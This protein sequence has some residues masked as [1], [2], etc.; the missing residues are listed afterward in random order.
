MSF[1][2]SSA[3]AAAYGIAVTGT[4]AI[5]SVIYFLVLTET[6]HWPRWKALPLVGL[7]LVF[8]LAFFGANLLKF[9]DGGWFPVGL[10]TVIFLIMTTWKKGRALLARNLADKLLPV[11]IFLEDLRTMNP[12]RVPG[13]AVFMSSNPNGVPVVLLH[14]WKHNQVLHQTV[15]LLSVISETLPEIPSSRRVVAKDL[16]QGF[17]HI[18]AFYGFMET[19]NVPELMQSA[20]DVHKVPYKPG[21][22]SYY[23]GRE[24]LLATK[25]SGM[26]PW[27]KMLFSFISRN[28]RSATQYFGIPP[29]RV[30]ELGMQI[31]L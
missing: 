31:D 23:L 9:P 11:S 20:A 27:R 22:T 17:F 4:M 1:K 28:S 30:V 13:T 7:F 18:T 24:T 14:H 8:D 16:G 5:T 26:Q 15:V 2:Q 6:W 21:S 3:L 12:P 25:K 29:D 19:P 10:A